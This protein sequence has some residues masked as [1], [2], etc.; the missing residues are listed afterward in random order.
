[1]CMWRKGITGTLNHSRYAAIITRI[2][3]QL[4]QILAEITL[5][6]TPVVNQEFMQLKDPF[7][8]P[9]KSAN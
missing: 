7:F 1:M 2:V 4:N 9:L 8:L 6:S 5:T 3:F